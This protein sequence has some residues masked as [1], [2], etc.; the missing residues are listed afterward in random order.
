LSRASRCAVVTCSG[1]KDEHVRPGAP[2]AEAFGEVP[3][4]GLDGAASACD[5]AS[6]SGEQRRH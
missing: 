3:S 6:A 2:L 1:G 4:A 5:G